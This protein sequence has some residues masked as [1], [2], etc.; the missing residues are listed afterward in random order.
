MSSGLLKL[1]KIIKTDTICYIT[2]FTANQTYAVR[3]RQRAKIWL[4][5][6][7]LMQQIVP[8][9]IILVSF[10]SPELICTPFQV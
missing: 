4:V 7:A 9:L 3:S 2:A 5:L 10:K 8:V 6:K 1:P